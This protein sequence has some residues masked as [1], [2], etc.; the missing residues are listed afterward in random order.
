MLE[1]SLTLAHTMTN[2][3]MGEVVG[4]GRRGGEQ[5]GRGQDG[6]EGIREAA[7]QR[8]PELAPAHIQLAALRMREGGRVRLVALVVDRMPAALLA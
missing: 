8:T 3:H 5:Q 6:D 7:A 1:R 4:W 2:T